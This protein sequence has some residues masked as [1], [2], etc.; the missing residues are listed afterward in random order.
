M[1]HAA[2][3]G[4]L[5]CRSSEFGLVAQATIVGSLTGVVHGGN[6]D[7]KARRAPAKVR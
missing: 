5:V 4:M 1:Q 6:M 7:V 2:R 3:L